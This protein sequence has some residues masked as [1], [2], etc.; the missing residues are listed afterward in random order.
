MRCSI[1][2]QEVEDFKPR[3]KDQFLNHAKRKAYDDQLVKKAFIVY[4]NGSFKSEEEKVSLEDVSLIAVEGDETV[5]NSSFSL[6]E[7]PVD[8]EN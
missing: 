5:F 6:M 1:Q 8:D 4:G 2:K 3:R 7:K